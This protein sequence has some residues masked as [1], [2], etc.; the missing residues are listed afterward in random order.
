MVVTY[1]LKKT[2]INFVRH[3]FSHLESEQINYYITEIAEL[4]LRSLR[5]NIDV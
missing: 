1:I 2:I 5:S 4:A 3:S